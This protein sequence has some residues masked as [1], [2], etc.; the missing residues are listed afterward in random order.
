[1][2]V[3]FFNDV[4]KQYNSKAVIPYNSSGMFD[5][6][7]DALMDDDLSIELG[8]AFFH[9]EKSG[10]EE[11]G[12][13]TYYPIYR[14]KRT[15]LQKM[16]YYWYNYK[17]ESHNGLRSDMLDIVND[18]KPDVI[19]IFGIESQFSCILGYTDIPVIVHLQ[20]FLNPTHN[21]F[22]PQGMNRY[23]FLLKK[24]SYNEWLFRNGYNFA[25]EHMSVRC[26]KE[27]D[28]FRNLQFS[29]GRTEWD[30]QIAQLL[31]P[32]TKYF[33]VD[34]LLREEF[35]RSRP[36]SMPALEKFVLVTNI[37]E[38]I[39]KGLDLILKTAKFL[40]EL[41]GIN[42]EWRII[43]VQANS[44]FVEFF[45][46]NFQIKSS[47]VNVRY[48]GVC[49]AEQICSLLLESHV[50]IHPSYIDNSPNSLCEAQL[51]GLPVI[52]TYV[53]GIPSLVAHRETGM[54][55]PSNAPYELCY[56]LKY[57]YQHPETMVQLG[58]AARKMALIRHS[59]EKIVSDLINVYH[60]MV[61]KAITP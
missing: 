30:Y 56:W 26:I 15:S 11:C 7:H 54:L 48:E 52:A 46:K 23:T 61:N 19:Q 45:E 18:F 10:R 36:W 5:T 35:M 13:T 8:V 43:G 44:R 1:M 59:K 25:A 50:Y 21:A 32:Q 29:L 60:Q 47:E 4:S 17:Q 58:H 33:H 27:R 28:Y 49:N 16:F 53:G 31:S 39:Y 12:K 42:F 22:Y 55:V 3:L 51:L 40:R 37:S 34:E 6:L 9:S 57:L 24:Y 41:T 38:T 14:K 2:K 20:G